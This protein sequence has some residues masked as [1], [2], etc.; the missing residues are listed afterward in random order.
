MVIAPIDWTGCLSKT[1]LKLVPPFTD[2]Q[3]P[4]LAEPTI[5]GEPLAFAHGIDRGNA[6]AHRGRADIARAQAGYRFGS[7]LTGVG[8][9]TCAETEDAK[10]NRQTIARDWTGTSFE[11]F[12]SLSSSFLFG[13][14]FGFKSDSINLGLDGDLRVWSV[15][16]RPVSFLQS[17]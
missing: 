13:K 9:G 5:N 15:V 14:S 11:L 4:P 16:L 7:T 1:G 10:Q 17:S 6:S 12:S 2:F 8:C 3:T